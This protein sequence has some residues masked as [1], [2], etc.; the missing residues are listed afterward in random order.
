MSFPRS[1][2]PLALSILTTSTAVNAETF[3]LK[4][5]VFEKVG[6]QQKIDPLLLYSIAIAESGM[7]IGGGMIRPKDLVLRYDGQALSFDNKE[8]AQS[9]L[10]S[11]LEKTNNVDVG[12]MQ[13]NLK[14]NPQPNPF[15]LFDPEKNIEAGAAI[16]STAMKSSP[17]NLI[18]GI[19][20]YHNWEDMDRCKW[21]GNMVLTIL[22][23]LQRHMAVNRG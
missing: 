20:R 11:I 9:K 16:L 3:T 6:L 8:E 15:A 12:I 7:G 18:I 21:Y 2:L 17:D 19:G 22:A 13:V 23:N 10:K 14:Y 4:G 1:F 5:S